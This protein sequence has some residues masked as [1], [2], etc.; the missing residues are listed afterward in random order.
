L[1]AIVG[2]EQIEFG[3]QLVGENDNGIFFDLLEDG[4]LLFIDPDT[5]IK[6][7]EHLPGKQPDAGGELAAEMGMSAFQASAEHLPGRI[8]SLLGFSWFCGCHSVLP[9]FRSKMFVSEVRALDRLW[10]WYCASVRRLLSVD[11]NYQNDL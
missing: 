4:R 9:L 3:F 2:K 1:I 5:G 11:S 7:F 8:A 6:Q 10:K